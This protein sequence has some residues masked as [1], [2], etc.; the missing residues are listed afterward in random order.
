MFLQFMPKNMRS[1][2]IMIRS[3]QTTMV[4]VGRSFKTNV[5]SPFEKEKPKKLYV[6]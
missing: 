1:S 3:N 2:R 5:E 6:N 4:G